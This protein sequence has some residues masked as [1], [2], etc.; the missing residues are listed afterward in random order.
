MTGISTGNKT[1]GHDH[2]PEKKATITM[3]ESPN[4]LPKY[5]QK[6]NLIIETIAAQPSMVWMKS[7]RE[8][9]QKLS[10]SQPELSNLVNLLVDREKVVKGEH[11][12]GMRGKSHV[13]ILKDPTL[14]ED[15]VS[16]SSMTT[17]T[18]IFRPEDR[19]AMPEEEMMGVT[20][21]RKI[22]SKMIGQAVI[23]ALKDVWQ[24]RDR[25]LEIRT[26]QNARMREY[27]EQLQRERQL[28]MRLADEREDS[29][30]QMEELRKENNELRTQ[31]NQALLR[32]GNHNGDGDGKVQAYPMRSAM[33]ENSRRVLDTLMRTKPGHYRES[34]AELEI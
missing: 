18:P 6:A 9:C 29:D 20:D 5:M 32:S 3:M 13:L 30:R 7:Q 16:R 34:D 14:F 21:L 2:K 17:S 12:P 19:V 22:D 8:L 4:K 23:G 15:T 31:L 25:N 1:V 28:R 10:I 33:D 24:E 27:R 26:E 11:I